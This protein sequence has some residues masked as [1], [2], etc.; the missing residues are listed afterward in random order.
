M[1]IKL[2]LAPSFR[3]RPSLTRISSRE[4]K[5]LLL[6][7]AMALLVG[8]TAFGPSNSR[9]TALASEE[10]ETFEL[11]VVGP[12][13]RPVADANIELRT[14]PLPTAEQIHVGKFLRQGTYGTLATTDSEGKL[15]VSRPDPDSAISVSIRA[16]GYGPYWAAWNP[17][18]HPQPVPAQFVAELDEGW[19]VGGIVVN[20]EG[21]P[22]EGVEVSPSVYFKKRPG[23]TETLG[24]GTRIVT[25]AD[26]E[27]R[28]DSVPASAD[29]VFVAFSHPDFMPNR[30][31]LTRSEFGLM[32]AESPTSL[33]ELQRGLVVRGRVTDESGDPVSDA[34]LR[35]KFL[36]DIR[37]ARSDADGNYEI[38]GCE[39]KMARIV[40]SAPGFATD[41]QEVRVDPDLPSVDFVMQPGGKIRVRVVD[42]MGNGIPRARIFFQDWRGRLSYFEFDHVHAYADDDGIWEWNEAPL[43]GFQADICRPGGMQLSRQSLIAREEEYVFSPP[44]PLV[45]SGSVVDAVTKQP[46]EI[47]RVIPGLRNR[48]PEI[49]MNWIDRDAYDASDGKYRVVFSHDYPS[50]LVR[51]EAEGY[52]VAISRDVKSDEGDVTFDF[53]L[54]P[55]EDIAATIVTPDGE[56]AGGAKIALGVAGS[57][58][59]I[60]NGEIDDRST[61]ATRLDADADGRF[62]ISDR[63]ESFQLVISHPSGFAHLKPDEQE[64]PRTIRLTPWG[65]VEGVFRVGSAPVPNVSLRLNTNTIHSYGSDVPNISTYHE[66]TTGLEGKYVFE[67]VVP[68]KGRIGR[69]ISLMVNDGA[70]E[71]TSSKQVAAEFP[72]GETTQLNLGGDGC[73]VV[74][75]I[76]PPPNA[77]QPPLWNFALVNASTFI[78]PLES[79]K[80]PPEAANDPELTRA[81][82]EQWE[83]SSEGRAWRSAYNTYQS[84]RTIVPYFTATVARDGTFR[85]DDVPSGRYVLSVRFSQRRAGEIRDHHFSIPAFD[86]DEPTPVFDLGDLQLQ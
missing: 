34:L 23:D 42:E 3:V 75:R 66:V 8:I 57:Q 22:V 17:D 47:F 16:P 2:R 28:F 55:A 83:A 84:L 69:S 81:W 9:G 71:V 46:I 25:N 80:P 82:R 43:D 1:N 51:I 27:W 74:G 61:F 37:E 31:P 10:G 35:T 68:G 70:T 33:V 73:A 56:P 6:F 11:I 20:S 18:K 24:V 62:R 13:G 36:N 39:P 72:P 86:Q 7:P 29:E 67:R 40:V 50:H 5:S 30:R 63:G 78:P 49:G 77:E 15:V 58:I 41:M 4:A 79:P 14:R 64:I 59:T 52:R 65:R 54:Q 21:K 32:A 76:L 12:N 26:G 38:I 53:E 60:L 44:P 45:V 48:D 85:I 19:A